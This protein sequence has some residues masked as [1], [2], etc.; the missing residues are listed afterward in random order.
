MDQQINTAEIEQLVTSLWGD[1]PV[2]VAVEPLNDNQG[3]IFPEEAAFLS[4]ASPR[5]RMAFSTGRVCARKAI[6][7]L[8]HPEAAVLV[9]E[10]R[11]PVWPAGLCGSISHGGDYVMAVVAKTGLIRSLGIDVEIA[12][13]LK[14]KLWRNVCVPEEIE[15][16]NA[17]NQDLN[18]ATLIFSAK[19]AFYK[20]QHIITK[21]W[22]GFKDA[23]VELNCADNTWQITLLK[24]IAEGFASGDS[25]QGRFCFVDGYVI[26]GISA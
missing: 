21:E 18:L 5:R 15:F 13:R 23:R 25:F 14:P 16:L 12:D 24:N 2:M 6:R 17:N 10:D 1:V 22:V 11:S 20:C 3:E 26:A 19:E 8:G 7:K 4:R 9:A